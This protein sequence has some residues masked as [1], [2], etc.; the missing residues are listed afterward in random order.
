MTSSSPT[1]IDP[2]QKE[3]TGNGKRQINGCRNKLLELLG[4]LL[5]RHPKCPPGLLAAVPAA[6]LSHASTYSPLKTTASSTAS[7]PA[8][9][10][11]AATTMV[12]ARP[13]FTAATITWWSEVPSGQSTAN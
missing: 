2:R 10:T 13:I 8:P 5:W 1:P 4:Y 9:A 6:G 12:P 7:H 11:S 3:G